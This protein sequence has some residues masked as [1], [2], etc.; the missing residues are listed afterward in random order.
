MG[1]YGYFG[2]KDLRILN[3]TS[4]YNAVRSANRLHFQKETLYRLAASSKENSG[5]S[6]H[7][8]AACDTMPGAILFD[9]ELPKSLRQLVIEKTRKND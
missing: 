1:R 6:N 5:F 3:P 9:T 4:L 2:E 7:A 8:Y